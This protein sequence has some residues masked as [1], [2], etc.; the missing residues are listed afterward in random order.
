MKHIVITIIT[1]YQV[2]F[3]VIVKQLLGIPM[4]CRFRPTCSLYTQQMILKH[5]ILKG[6]SKGIMRIL[7]CHPYSRYGTI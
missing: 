2:I 6:G 4:I 5:G 7:S 1:F 3:S